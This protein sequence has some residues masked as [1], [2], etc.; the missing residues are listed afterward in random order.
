[1]SRSGRAGRPALVLFEQQRAEKADDG[2]VIWKNAN[3]LVLPISAHLL[4]YPLNFGP[5]FHM[6]YFIKPDH[7]MGAHHSE[8]IPNS[9]EQAIVL[10]ASGLLLQGKLACRS[11]I[12]AV[13]AKTAYIEPGSPWENGYCESFNARFRDELLNGELFYTLKDAQIL[14]E[15][16]RIHYNTV[17]PNSALGYR[18]PAPESIVSVDQRP[19]MH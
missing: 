18:P 2:L 7:P 1:V 8:P 3:G 6:T 10:K 11:W 12:A 17:R 15:Q 4:R 5:M 14:I 19:T 16:W 13:D 9:S